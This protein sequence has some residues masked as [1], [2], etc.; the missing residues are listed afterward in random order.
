MGVRIM[1]RRAGKFI[2]LDKVLVQQI[3]KMYPCLKYAS[4]ISLSSVVKPLIKKY[5]SFKLDELDE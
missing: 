3:T 1:T 2:P 5:D 4:I